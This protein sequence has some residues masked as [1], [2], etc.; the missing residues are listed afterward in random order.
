MLAMVN[1]AI[2]VNITVDNEWKKRY[3]KNRDHKSEI[4]GIDKTNCQQKLF[5]V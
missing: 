1:S 4:R 3:D 2:I 5:M